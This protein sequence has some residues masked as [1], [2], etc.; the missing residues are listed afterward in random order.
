VAE[1]EDLTRSDGELL[2]TR[3]EQEATLEW[4]ACRRGFLAHSS[5]TDGDEAAAAPPENDRVIH[6]QVAAVI[7]CVVRA[8]VTSV[9]TASRRQHCVGCQ[10]AT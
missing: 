2:R 10:I 8:V 9:R 3:V 4:D 1:D 5:S 7:G 6:A